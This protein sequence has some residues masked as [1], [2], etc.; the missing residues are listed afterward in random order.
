[1]QRD[2][3]LAGAGFHVANV[4]SVGVDVALGEGGGDVHHR[5]SSAR[6]CDFRTLP[7]DE[8]GRL[9][10]DTMWRGYLNPAR[11]SRQYSMSAVGLIS[12]PGRAAT[13]ATT[14][15]PRSG[16]GSPSTAA[17][18]TAGCSWRTASTSDGKT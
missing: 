3:R 14:S 5:A 7:E 9:E 4:E 10:T 11:R 17:S 16:W 18:A 8:R 1:M 6:S 12:C 15:S 2:Q 13:K